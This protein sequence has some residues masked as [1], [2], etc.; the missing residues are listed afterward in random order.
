MRVE[1]MRKR[2]TAGITASFTLGGLDIDPCEEPGAS[3][4]SFISYLG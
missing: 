2:L 4:E 1:M 3:M